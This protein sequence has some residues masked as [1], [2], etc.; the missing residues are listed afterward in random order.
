MSIGMFVLI[1]AFYFISLMTAV[2]IGKQMAL[3]AATQIMELSL[4]KTKELIGEIGYEQATDKTEETKT[5]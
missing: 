1:F 2:G 3:E 4:M 5:P